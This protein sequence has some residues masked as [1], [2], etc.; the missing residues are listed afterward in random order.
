MGEI[1]VVGGGLG[2]L[3][4]AVHLARA[5]R[6]VTVLEGSRTLGGRARSDE[7][8]GMILNLGPHALYRGAEEAL[9]ALGVAVT[10]G[11]PGGADGELTMEMAGRVTPLPTGLLSLLAIPGL[12]WGDK[13]RL[14]RLLAGVGRTRN[15]PLDRVSVAEWLT[16][17]GLDGAARDVIE[18]TVRVSTYCNAPCDLSA[19]AVLRQLSTALSGVRYIDGGWGSIVS[20]LEARARALGVTI[21]VGARVSAVHVAKDGGLEVQLREGA[22]LSADGV[23]LTTSPKA[24][25][26]LLGDAAPESLGA[27]AAEATAVRAACL[28]VALSTLPRPRPSLV[29]GTERPLYLSVHSHRAR[30]APPGGAVIHVARYLA[31]GDAIDAQELRGELEGLLDAHQPGWREVLVEA[32]FSPAMTVMHALPEAARGGL[33]GRP[34]VDAGPRGVALVGDWI[35]PDGMLLDAV[36]ESARAAAEHLTSENLASENLASEDMAARSAHR[37]VA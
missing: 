23:V 20:A 33:A 35:G 10:G 15:G 28:D 5:G 36:L 34:R 14:A 32:R 27:F 29:L 26:R 9:R 2:G 37:R 7:R 4:A 6:D 24:T 22:P 12:G 19:G 18:A 25:V 3:A 1:V 11:V 8:D 17:S 30:L 31:P 13:W 16:R 21:R